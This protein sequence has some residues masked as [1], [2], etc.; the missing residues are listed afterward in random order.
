MLERTAISLESRGLQR[1]IRNSPAGSRQLHPGFW[2]HGASAIDLSSAL[3]GSSRLAE[4]EAPESD[5]VFS[6]QQST[7][8]ASA[9]MLDFLYPPTSTIPLLRRM[10]PKLPS[11]QDGH[12]VALLPQRRPFS[13][14]STPNT[15]EPAE[16]S[17]SPLSNSDA[18]PHETGVAGNTSASDAQDA[19]EAPATDSEPSELQRLYNL[20]DTDEYQFQ[21]AWDLYCVIDNDQRRAVRGELIQYLANSHG[22]V[23]TGRAV[24]VFRQIPVEEWNEGLLTSGI[25]LLLRAGDLPAAVERFKTGLEKKGLS[26]GL[27]YLLADT[28]SSQ[29]WSTALD[30]WIAYYAEQLKSSEEETPTTDRL[31]Q[32]ET[33]PNQGNLYF[34]FRTYLATDGAEQYKRIKSDDDSSLAFRVFR[35]HFAKMALMQPCSPEQAAIILETLNDAGLYND[36]FIRMFDRWYDKKETRATV[37]KLPAIYQKFREMPNVTP[38]MP[39]FRGMFKVNFPKNTARLD[40]LYND[41]IRFKGGLNQWG[42][43]KFL[44]LYAHK[45]DVPT[46]RRLWDEY[47]TAFPYLLK[48]PRAF[49]STLNVYS[50]AGDIDGAWAELENM[51]K[52]HG[53]QP[54]IDCWNTVLKGYMR[55]NDY[56]KVLSC[57]DEI[58]KQHEPDSFTYAHVMAMSSKKGDLD[59]T[60][61][62]FARS[63]EAQIPISKEMCLGLVVA[64]CQNDLLL[65]AEALCIEMTER[66]LTHTVIW[67]QL[68]NFNGVEGKVDKVYELLRRMREYGVEWDDETYGFL[69]Q[70]LVKVNQIHPAYSLLKRADDEKLF[71]VTPGHFAIVMAGAARVGEYELVESLHHRL[72][73]SELPVSFSALVALVSAAAKRKPGVQRS[74]DLANEFVVHF[75]EAVEASKGR[76]TTSGPKVSDAGNLAKLREESQHVGRAIML[77]VE[78]R[79]LGSA[80]ELMSLFAQVFPQYQ[81]NDGFPP[82]VVSA[83]MLAH[84]KDGNYDKVLELWEKTWER[85]LAT[86]QKR[87]GDGIYAGSKYELSRV[88]NI[89]AR[90]YKEKED[91][92][93]LSETVD[94]MTAAGF[95]LTRANWALVVRY[96]AELGRWERAMYWCETMLMPGWRGWNPQ[97]SNKEKRILQ[98]TQILKAPKNVVYRLQQQWLDMRKMAA[99]SEDVSRQVSG[100]E[101]KYPRLYHAFTTSEI[102]SMP[103]TYVLNGREVSARDLDKVLQSMSYHELMK[104]KEALLRQLGKEKKREQGL[105]ITPAPKTIQDQKEWKTMLHNKVR[106]YA[107]MWAK[108]RRRQ[109]ANSSAPVQ[110]AQVEAKDNAPEDPDQQASRETFGYWNDFWDRYD[111][112]PH[113][114]YQHRKKTSPNKATYENKAHR[115]NNTPHGD[116]APGRAAKTKPAARDLYEEF[117]EQ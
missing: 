42:Y 41:W 65:E 91:P 5:A 40:E 97:R 44:K 62:F 88:L 90:V 18:L 77:L 73:K 103:T 106:R 8:L 111:Q 112:R 37:E 21:E 110:A 22:V 82:Y 98:N 52:K 29:E 6:Q 48:S 85:V 60:L 92:R 12:R 74:K 61:E 87:T 109:S 55:V 99:W 38:A 9:L 76:H 83:L 93:G 81:G 36:Y 79:E 13:S 116:N 95:K 2:Q 23:E 75:R 114:R 105:G 117:T 101:E 14:D 108:R 1:V 51:I 66:K 45:G 47:M 63:Q 34:A 31:E 100:V 54:D 16:P 113:G 20:L 71:L 3:P 10:Y 67:N 7:L 72:Q 50:Q 33:L 104:V 69:L 43:E 19:S 84:Y 94:K 11:S 25:L 27:E 30:V 28:I 80:E 78:L 26:G 115:G 49:R 58:S 59:T 102:E 15:T 57:F 64:Y 56:D 32:L 89:V 24:S 70:A 4:S 17:Q 68:L 96:L 39:V 86:S 46:V 107:A 53:V 35:R